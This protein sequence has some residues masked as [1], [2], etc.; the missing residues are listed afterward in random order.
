MKLFH[1][2]V[3]VIVIINNINNNTSW[4]RVLPTGR[5]AAT[6][7]SQPGNVIRINHEHLQIP[8]I[9]GSAL[10]T[11]V[12]TISSDK[13]PRQVQRPETQMSPD[14]LSV[15]GKQQAVLYRCVCVW[16]CLCVSVCV[17]VSVSVSG[18]SGQIYLPAQRQYTKDYI[19]RHKR[20]S[21]RPALHSCLQI[22]QILCRLWIHAHAR[23]GKVK[24]R[25]PVQNNADQY[26]LL[27]TV[28]ST[29]RI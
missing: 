2:R 24:C 21:K 17:C 6:A 19:R 26:K 4:L 9:Y 1:E 22:T 20:N 25:V 28:L 16:V 14:S 3:K 5:A 10:V 13:A 27:V 7:T 23:T 18:P 29:D 11:A 12:S 8:T 15:S